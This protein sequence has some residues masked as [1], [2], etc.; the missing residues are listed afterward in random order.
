MLRTLP[1]DLELFKNQV[2]SSEY[3]A[4]VDKIHRNPGCIVNLQRFEGAQHDH[5]VA[6]CTTAYTRLTH[7]EI[8]DKRGVTDRLHN[9]CRLLGAPN[10][11]TDRD[12]LKEVEEVVGAENTKEI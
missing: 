12:V 10:P 7:A 1:S 9:L 11:E 5:E 6:L 3:F 2:K 4:N 8:W